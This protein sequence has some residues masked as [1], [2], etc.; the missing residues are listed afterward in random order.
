MFWP[1]VATRD[2]LNSERRMGVEEPERC[3][4][5]GGQHVAGACGGGR[6]HIDPQT[7]RRAYNSVRAAFASRRA[8]RTDSVSICCAR[9]FRRG[10]V[11]TVASFRF[12]GLGF[13]S[14]VVLIRLLAGPAGK[15][16]VMCR[17]R[18]ITPKL[19]FS[20]IFFFSSRGSCP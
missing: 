4:W 2:N 18:K 13:H 11:A 7:A 3:R 15:R 9:G 20:T 19:R 5:G 12:F 16:S 10:R 6:D 17:L 8:R 14:G 1:A